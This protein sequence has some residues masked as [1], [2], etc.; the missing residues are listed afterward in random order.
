[1][2]DF[3]ANQTIIPRRY[4]LSCARQCIDVF[5]G[6]Q[7][8]LAYRVPQYDAAGRGEGDLPSIQPV[9]DR[10]SMK[11]LVQRLVAFG[12]ALAPCHIFAHRIT[13]VEAASL[14]DA[15][16]MGLSG[17]ELRRLSQQK[18]TMASSDLSGHEAP[19]ALKGRPM[20]GYVPSN[21]ER[22]AGAVASSQEENAIFKPEIKAS[23][24]AVRRAV[25]QRLPS[26]IEDID[27]LG[28]MFFLD[29]CLPEISLL[30]RP[31]ADA[32]SL[33]YD[34][35]AGAPAEALISG[36]NMAFSS[37]EDTT[38]AALPRGA[39]LV[40]AFRSEADSPAMICAMQRGY[41]AY[42]QAKR[43]SV[44][45]LIALWT[46]SNNVTGCHA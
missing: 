38:S 13:A 27:R 22:E 7:K 4:N 2:L 30:I 28:L 29:S 24:G 18:D 6:H 36:L 15:A 39:K 23:A 42:A 31:G 41:W 10:D 35:A 45:R 26:A 34:N 43:E 9:I 5:A 14:P 46:R 37:W 12:G 16:V 33:S 21:R 25:D 40:C 11:F 17:A 19:H 1:V 3:V 20:E 8:I 44:G 32:A